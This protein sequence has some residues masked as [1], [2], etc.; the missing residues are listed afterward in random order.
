MS[1]QTILSVRDVRVHFNV[2]AKS[3]LPWAPSRTLKAVDGV[4]FD[5]KAGETLAVVGESGCGKS[6]LCRAVL[7][8]IRATSGEV[9][10]RGQAIQQLS[11]RNMR[12]LR[13]DMQ[14][15]FQ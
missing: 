1:E 15:V 13:R 9:V 11:A 7:G 12:P 10:W 14:M 2:Q 4:S 8:L 3:K 5:L 6:T